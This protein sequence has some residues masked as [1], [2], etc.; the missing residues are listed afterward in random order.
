MHARLVRHDLHLALH[1]GDFV[2]RLDQILAVQV[3]VRADALVQAA[4]M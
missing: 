1:L 4:G 3:A 2:L